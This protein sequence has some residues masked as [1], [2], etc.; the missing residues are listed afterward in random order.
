MRPDMKDIIIDGYRRGGGYSL[1]PFTRAR[2]KAMS[3]EDVPTHISNKYVINSYPNDRL[4]PLDKFLESNAGRLWNDVYSE[5]REHCDT[6]SIRGQHLWEHVV[7]GVLYPPPWRTRRGA[8]VDEDGVLQYIPRRR[9]SYRLPPPRVT[10]L[11][12][13]DDVWYEWFPFVNHDGKKYRVQPR[14][15]W[16]LMVRTWETYTTPIYD[17]SQ[18]PAVQIGRSEPKYREVITKRQ[19]SKRQLKRIK[20]K[21]KDLR[22]WSKIDLLA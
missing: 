16:Y 15:Q 6:R 4:A 8:Y 12:V 18:R 9:R 7:E 13:S 1:Q 22:R 19:C 21:L 10:T 5:I 2:L 11:P 17:Y 3:D 14:A 20:D